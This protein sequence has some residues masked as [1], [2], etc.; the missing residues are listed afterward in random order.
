MRPH[1]CFHQRRVCARWCFH[2]Q[3]KKD[4]LFIVCDNT[5][6]GRGEKE[7]PSLV[8]SPTG[9]EECPVG[10][11]TN[12]ENDAPVGV[13]TNREKKTLFSSFVK[14]QTMAEEC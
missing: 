3:R 1:W 11:F 2:Q 4:P 8:F 14:T 10:V 13:F 6:D 7:T 9:E 12:E 5:N